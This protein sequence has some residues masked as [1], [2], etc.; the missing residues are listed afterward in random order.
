MSVRTRQ[1]WGE[2][3]GEARVLYADSERAADVARF[4]LSLSQLID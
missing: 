4:V 1:M 2:G 3:E